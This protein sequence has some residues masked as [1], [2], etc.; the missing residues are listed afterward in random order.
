MIFP[1]QKVEYILKRVSPN[2]FDFYERITMNQSSFAHPTQI[3]E[4]VKM[5][6]G[7]KQM[8]RNFFEIVRDVFA[9]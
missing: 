7:N 9:L 8:P 3:C 2:I 6:Q 4:G 5:N 1:S